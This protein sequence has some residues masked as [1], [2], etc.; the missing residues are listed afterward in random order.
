MLRHTHS[1]RSVSDFFFVF[2]CFINI[3]GMLLPK[4]KMVNILL[5]QVVLNQNKFLSS[6]ENKNYLEETKQLMYPSDFY[7]IFF[8]YG[9]QWGTSTVLL[10]TFIIIS[11][12]VF[13]TRNK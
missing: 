13:S 7:S 12:F 11:S 4:I 8:S 10:P 6:V 3:K 5:F 2:C 9:S 1:E